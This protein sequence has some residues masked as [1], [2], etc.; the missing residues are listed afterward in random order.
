MVPCSENI[1]VGSALA[2][3]VSGT[4]RRKP[5]PASRDSAKRVRQG[6]PYNC[7]AI[8]DITQPRTSRHA[9]GVV[10]ADFFYDGWQLK[11]K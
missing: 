2:D 11:K 9:A 7:W 3:A 10:D 8:M 4:S 1:P 5:G 6:G